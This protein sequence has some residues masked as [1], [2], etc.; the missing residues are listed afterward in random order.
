MVM[1]AGYYDR[2]LA[3]TSGFK[4][5]VTCTALLTGAA[6]PVDRFDQDVDALVT[7]KGISICSQAGK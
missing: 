1:G 3:L 2:F 5:G 6:L 4:L 7:E